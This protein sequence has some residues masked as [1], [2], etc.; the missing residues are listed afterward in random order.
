MIS[1][2]RCRGS[3]S[4]QSTHRI[5]TWLRGCYGCK[6]A[7][8]ASL[9]A[10][11]VNVVEALGLGVAGVRFNPPYYHSLLKDAG[12]E[13]EKGYVN[14]KIKVCPELVARWESAAEAG[15]RAGFEIAHVKDL[16]ASRWVPEFTATFNDAYKRHWGST[17][18]SQ[19]EVEAYVGSPDWID[20][21]LLAYRDGEPAGILVIQ[22]DLSA[23]ASLSP[24]RKLADA[25]KLN[26]LG[27]GVAESSR[28]RG[29]NLAMASSAYLELAGQGA[30][31]LSY[32]LVLDDNW[33][34]R[35]T[36]EKLGASVCSSHVVYRRNFRRG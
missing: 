6:P 17:P 23:G 22:N 34:S 7:L 3:F 29:L 27:I 5:F 19:G 10:E 30:K 35:R 11:T 8:P 12:F 21:S 18:L 24:G 25:E 33:P 20:H 14:Y 26:W 36:A 13:T 4:H 31:Y 9:G 2:R 16:P 1:L 28:G 32:T 15:R